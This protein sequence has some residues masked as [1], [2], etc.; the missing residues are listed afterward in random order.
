M[1][2]TIDAISEAEAAAVLQEYFQYRLER[3]QLSRSTL[4]KYHHCLKTYQNWLAGEVITEKSAL[5]FLLYLEQEGFTPTT[6]RCY[7]HAL[8]PFL[9]YLGMPLQKQFK[10]EHKQPTY[11]KPSEVKAILHAIEQRHDNWDKLKARD[12]LIVLTFAY[13]GIR[14]GEL[15]GLRVRDLN[16]HNHMLKVKGKGDKERAIPIADA[17]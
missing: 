4:D 11:H 2:G 15:L 7:Y 8:K 16:Y 14:R 9:A 12:T 6:C 13:T 3:C 17:L 1:R 10:R 5:G